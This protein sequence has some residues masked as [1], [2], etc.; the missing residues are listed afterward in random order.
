MNLHFFILGI[1]FESTYVDLL[2]LFHFC[3]RC[4]WE[5]YLIYIH[6]FLISRKC[7]NVHIDLDMKCGAIFDISNRKCVCVCLRESSSL[8][9][10]SSQPSSIV[11]LLRIFLANAASE[12]L[13]TWFFTNQEKLK[14][15]SVE[16]R[17]KFTPMGNHISGKLWH[18][19]FFPL[20][21]NSGNQ[22][23]KSCFHVRTYSLSVHIYCYSKNLSGTFY[24]CVMCVFL[25]L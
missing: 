25:N 13:F 7:M 15:N 2:I 22:Q 5:V 17:L 11:H 9:G 1:Y 4:L 16:K 18:A 6:I 14:G 21:S 3:I 20:S 8:R 19:F 12:M 24:I 23:A 10:F